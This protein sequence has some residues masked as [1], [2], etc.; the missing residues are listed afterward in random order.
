MLVICIYVYQYLLSKQANIVSPF[1]KSLTHYEATEV[2]FN[3]NNDYHHAYAI[4]TNSPTWHTNKISKENKI[5]KTYMPPPT[6]GATSKHYIILYYNILYWIY[7][8]LYW[9]YIITTTKCNK[10]L[11]VWVLLLSSAITIAWSTGPN[12]MGGY[13]PIPSECASL[14]VWLRVGVFRCCCCWLR[15]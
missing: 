14:C 11:Y 4:S 5:I 3:E 12:R 15:E 7:V 1:Q 6:P 2:A 9:T 8:G 10:I 13:G